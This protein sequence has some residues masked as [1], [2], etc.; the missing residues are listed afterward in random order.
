MVD[1][2][3]H[4]AR[5]GDPPR[6]LRRLP[7][8]GP[9]GRA[10]R[11]RATCSG[12]GTVRAA[13]GHMVFRKAVHALRR[14]RCGQLRACPACGGD[15]VAMRTDR[16][17]S[18]CRPACATASGC[19]CRAR[20]TPA[21]AARRRAISTS[22]CTSTPHPRF[23]RDGDDLHLDVPV[24]IHEAAFGARIDVPSPTRAV[25][26][27]GAAGHAVGPAVPR[28][29]ARHAVAARRARR[30]TSWPRCVWCCRRSTTNGRARWSASSPGRIRTT[31]A[32]WHG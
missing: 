27:A 26:A 3:R 28:A 22:P 30:A 32:A 7:G 5:H 6:P 15:G 25:P 18:R 31:C 14:H 21:A 13:R 12:T 9:A 10:R 2:G 24:A 19:A 29:R 11:R 8:R 1:A 23:R 20:A 4:R 16:S 17:R